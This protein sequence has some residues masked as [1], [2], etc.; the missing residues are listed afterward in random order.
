MDLFKNILPK[1]NKEHLLSFN[2]FNWYLNNSESTSGHVIV[3]KKANITDSFIIKHGILLDLI[4]ND[5][6]Y[7]TIDYNFQIVLI[8]V[9]SNLNDLKSKIQYSIEAQFLFKEI[10]KL[11]QKTLVGFMVQTV[12]SKLNVV[13]SI[14]Y[15][16]TNSKNELKKLIEKFEIILD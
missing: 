1:F 6:I 5:M 16:D 3:V 12:D 7:Q 14:K 4:E 9:D 11:S 8:N 13:N 10:K 2:L 15:P